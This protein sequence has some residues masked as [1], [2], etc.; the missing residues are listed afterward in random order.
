MFS[1]SMHL[2]QT[3]FGKTSQQD[4]QRGSCCLCS[5]WQRV[6]AMFYRI[7]ELEDGRLWKYQSVSGPSNIHLM[8]C[9]A[10]QMLQM[11]L[12]S[13]SS[14]TGHAACFG[15]HVSCSCSNIESLCHDSRSSDIQCPLLVY[16]THQ[17]IICL[18]RRTLKSGLLLLCGHTIARTVH[19]CHA[20]MHDLVCSVRMICS[21]ESF[22]RSLSSL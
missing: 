21:Q 15:Q 3:D 17:Q 2:P 10:P 16:S 4:I 13:G 6:M 9:V 19:H 11:N 5:M 22:A 8:V 7:Q 12:L 1:S 20:A 14:I 18:W